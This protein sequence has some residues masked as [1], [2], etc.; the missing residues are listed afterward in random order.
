M[1]G[2][3]FLDINDGDGFPIPSAVIFP[4]LG[5]VPGSENKA[6]GV[7]KVGGELFLA[8]SFQFVDAGLG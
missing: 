4:W 1:G 7:A 2:G 8:V 5:V 6:I 3:D